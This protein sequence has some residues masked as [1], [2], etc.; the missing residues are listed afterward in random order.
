MSNGLIVSVF[1]I[2][3]LRSLTSQY[4]Q[5]VAAVVEELVEENCPSS[6][7]GDET[8][9]YQ[10]LQ[11][12]AVPVKVQPCVTISGADYVHD[13][14]KDVITVCDLLQQFELEGSEVS[15]ASYCSQLA[16]L[17]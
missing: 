4:S 14:K 2:A 10:L 8:T 15:A 5:R 17:S 3:D 12:E 16:Y 11:H 13:W 1:T 6:G 9:F 7:S